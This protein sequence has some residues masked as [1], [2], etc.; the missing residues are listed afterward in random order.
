MHLRIQRL[1]KNKYN[2]QCQC[3][4]F[5]RELKNKVTGIDLLVPDYVEIPGKISK[6]AVFNVIVITRLFYYKSKGQKES[7]V[8]QFTVSFIHFPKF[9]YE[10]DERF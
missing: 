8:V 9:F 6:S 10:V 2:K 4:L 3:H 7:D 5:T 1:S